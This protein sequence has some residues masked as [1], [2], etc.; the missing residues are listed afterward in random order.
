MAAI[1][2]RLHSHAALSCAMLLLLCLDIP[3]TICAVED[4]MEGM[5]HL[6]TKTSVTVTELLP[7]IGRLIPFQYWTQSCHK[8]EGGQ[9]SGTKIYENGKCS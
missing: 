3:S 1:T 7:Y 6:Q 4:R 8:D 2:G 9:L 5:R